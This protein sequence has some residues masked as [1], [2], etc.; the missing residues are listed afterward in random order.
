MCPAASRNFRNV[1]ATSNERP[2]LC[3][4]NFKLKFCGEVDLEVRNPTQVVSYQLELITESYDQNSGGIS[5][6]NAL[7]CGGIFVIS[8][9]GSFLI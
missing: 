8:G 1:A 9:S 5:W 3:R 7:M 4:W 2:G 6:K